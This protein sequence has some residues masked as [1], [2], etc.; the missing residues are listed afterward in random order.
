MTEKL[1]YEDSHMIT[2]SAIVEACVKRGEYYEAVLNRTAFFPEG[3]GQYADTGVIG[4]ESVLDVQEREGI[5]YHK[6]KTPLEAGQT[7]EGAIDWEERF[8]KMQQHS[9]EHIVSG[10]VNAMYGYDNVG[11]H[12]GRDAITMDFSGVLS[13]EQL[14]EIEQKANEAVVKNLDIEVLYPS[15]EELTD[16]AYRSKIEIEGQVRIVRVPG[17]DTC[18]CCAPHVKKTGEIGLIKL[19]GVQNYKGGVRVSMLCGFR[20]IADYE[21]KAESV[22]RISVMLSAK[23]AE[24]AEEVLKLKEEIASQKGKL[25]EMQRTLLKYKVNE[26]PENQDLVILFESGLEGSEPRELM[27]LVLEKKAEVAAVFAGNDDKGYRYVMGSKT[28]DMRP[29][30]KTLNELFQGRGGGKPE[31]VQGSLCGEEEKIREAVKACKEKAF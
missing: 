11:F 20:A 3:G 6:M 17:Y 1:F 16:M 5:I 10:L 12:M 8:S 24:V 31:M 25:I 27:N 7:V 4:G 18:A 29:F 14:K 22:K 13:K 21:E 28:R 23:E 19:I 26:I 15:K 30:A 9:G 2:F